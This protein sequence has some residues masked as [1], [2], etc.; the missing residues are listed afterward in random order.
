ME[1]YDAF[2][3]DNLVV[4]CCFLQGIYMQHL[5]I[6]KPS[7]QSSSWIRSLEWKP[8]SQEVISMRKALMGVPLSVRLRWMSHDG[9][10][11]LE[12]IHGQRYEITGMHH[13]EFDEWVE[14]KSLGRFFHERIKPFYSMG[15][16]K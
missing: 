13:N 5:K 9:S 3:E 6:T 10:T 7:K 14:A 8:L 1:R 4:L 12:T 15:G 11:I 16:R 2:L